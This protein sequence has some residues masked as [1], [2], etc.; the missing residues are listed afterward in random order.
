MCIYMYI[1]YVYCLY[2]RCT[3]NLI[4]SVEKQICHIELRII[5]NRPVSF[6]WY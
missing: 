2:N 1:E 5:S 6:A 3:I 4:C